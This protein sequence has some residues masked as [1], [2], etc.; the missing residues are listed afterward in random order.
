MKV[1]IAIVGGGPAGSSTALFLVRRFGIDPGSIAIFD[2]ARHP[3][4]KPCAGAISRAGVAALATI[5]VVPNVPHRTMAGLAVKDG[6]RGGE[7]VAYNVGVVV[8]RSEFDA[9][10]FHTARRDGVHAHDGV[11]VTR[12]R[13]LGDRFVLETTD[14][15]VGEVQASL[16]AVCEGASSTVRRSLGLAEPARKGHLYVTETRP[17]PNDAG[18]TNGVCEFDLSPVND[19]VEGYYWDFPTVIEGQTFVSRGIYHANL[20]PHGRVKDVL[21]A[22]LRTRGIDLAACSLRPFA[23]RPFVPQ[24]TTWG[25]GFVL[26]GEAAGIDR[27]TGEGIAQAIVAGELGAGALAHALRTRSRDTSGFDRALRRSTTG[28]HLLQSAWFADRVFSARGAPFRRVLAKSAAAK[29]AGARWYEGMP[30]PRRDKVS[31]GLS[32]AVEWA[33]RFGDQP[34]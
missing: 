22:C 29:L 7:S 2:K 31:L 19:G 17:T 28:R 15:D 23:T 6:D 14:T 11:G 32:L 25:E 3:R 26:V 16:L 24:S 34:F 8:R 9:H 33:R 5:G 30:I 4:D 20:T 10:L 13:D 1:D 18:P 12:V 27:T 21:G